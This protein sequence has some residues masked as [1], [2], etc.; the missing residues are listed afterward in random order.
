M[1]ADQE[2]VVVL[3]GEALAC[4]LQQGVESGPVD[5][6]GPLAG[7]VAAHRGDR[8]PPPG[9]APHSHHGSLSAPVPGA[10]ARPSSRARPRARHVPAHGGPG[11]LPGPAVA[12]QEPPHSRDRAP[13]LEL[14]ADQ[15]SDTLQSP[16]LIFPAMRTRTFGQLLFQ[17]GEPLVRQ[18]RHF[19]GS[20]RLQ[21]LHTAFTP[22][23]APLLHRRPAQGNPKRSTMPDRVPLSLRPTNSRGNAIPASRSSSLIAAV[24]EADQCGDTPVRPM[25]MHA[26]WSAPRFRHRIRRRTTRRCPALSRA[27]CAATDVPHR[28]GAPTADRP[29]DQ[30]RPV[31]CATP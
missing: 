7:P 6:P 19:R 5:Q 27:R 3:P 8:D 12:V 15:R 2:I 21:T 30:V 9:P 18:L 25:T 26:T 14:A 23:A 29:L 11:S 24:C 1:R 31:A 20:L 22:V 13:D 28:A 17:H 4:T 10:A 16:P